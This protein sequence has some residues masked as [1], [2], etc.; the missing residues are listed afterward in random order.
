MPPIE[1]TVSY[2]LAEYLSVVRDYGVWHQATEGGKR[3][4]DLVTRGPVHR[5]IHTA[6]IYLLAP[7]I[8][9]LKKRAVGQCDFSIDQEQIVRRSK[10]IDVRLPWKDVLRVHRLSQAYLVEKEGGA[11]PLPYR[12]FMPTQRQAFEAVLAQNSVAMVAA[13]IAVGTPITGRPPHRSER[14]Q[15]RHSAPT[16]GLIDAKPS[17]RPGMKNSWRG[18]PTCK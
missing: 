13:Q 17:F 2:R 11:M 10:A 12:A 15:L 6:T 7:P 5:V 9:L 14:A 4:R 18:Q 3:E 8:F 16:S 1:I